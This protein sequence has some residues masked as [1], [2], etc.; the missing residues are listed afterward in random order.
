MKINKDFVWQVF[1]EIVREAKDGDIVID[2]WHYHMGFFIKDA[3]GTKPILQINDENTF[4]DLLFTYVCYVQKYLQDNPQFVTDQL[5]FL[6]ENEWVKLKYLVKAILTFMMANFSYDDFLKPEAFVLRKI[7]ALDEDIF[8][9]YENETLLLAKMEDMGSKFNDLQLMVVK[10]KESLAKESFHSLGF[11]LKNGKDSYCLPKI[12]Y[13]IKDNVCYITGIQKD[14]EDKTKFHKDLERAFYKVDHDVPA[15]YKNIE[16][17]VLIA[18]TLFLTLL[19]KEGIIDVVANGFYPLR[20]DLKT[21]KLDKHVMDENTYQR[22]FYNTVERFF[23][24]F[25]RL[26]YHFPEYKIMNYPSDCYMSM[27]VHITPIRAV[28]EDFL[29]QLR[30][31]LI[32][33]APNVKKV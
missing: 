19:E 20:S 32:T 25:V 31:Q 27:Y 15:E 21:Y 7:Q 33:A 17:N 8:T 6:E 22:I 16:P 28:K 18:L 12:Y 9:K 13:E 3:D 1:K 2:D 14:K 30:E 26:A 10:K 11:T 24:A 29:T 23:M 4:K 5:L